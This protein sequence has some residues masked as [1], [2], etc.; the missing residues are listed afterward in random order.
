MENGW[1]VGATAVAAAVAAIELDVEVAKDIVGER[2]RSAA[3]AVDADV[4]TVL[5]SHIGPLV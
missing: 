1:G 2:R 5:S 3:L 4:A